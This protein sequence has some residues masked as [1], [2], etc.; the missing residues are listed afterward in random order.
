MRMGL[1]AVDGLVFVKEHRLPTPK[2]P[3]G[4][5]DGFVEIWDAGAKIWDVGANCVG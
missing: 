1:E 4:L 3:E 5:A 2:A